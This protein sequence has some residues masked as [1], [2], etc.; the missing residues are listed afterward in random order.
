MNE[1][2]SWMLARKALLN[3]TRSIK[4]SCMLNTLIGIKKGWPIDSN[5]R[6]KTDFIN[7]VGI[8]RFTIRVLLMQFCRKAM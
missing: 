1:L 3:G 7:F 2:M 6:I 8:K 5:R 4:I